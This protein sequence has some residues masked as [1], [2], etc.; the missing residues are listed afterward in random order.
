MTETPIFTGDSYEALLELNPLV[1]IKHGE[2]KHFPGIGGISTMQHLD[3]KCLKPNALCVKD[4]QRLLAN[5]ENV[6]K[7]PA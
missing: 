1:E 3:S 7:T 4:V 6:N 5:L 2:M